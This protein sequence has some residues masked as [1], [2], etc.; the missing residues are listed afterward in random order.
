MPKLKLDP[1]MLTVESF[2]P[3]DAA[4]G[5]G[6]TIRGNSFVTV[7]P[8]QPCGSEEPSANCTDTVDVHLYTCGV[9]CAN[10]CLHTGPEAGC[11][12]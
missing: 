7:Q 4:E 2:A 10:A 1:E 3:A 12:D 11:V 8:H 5:A 6:G 9:S